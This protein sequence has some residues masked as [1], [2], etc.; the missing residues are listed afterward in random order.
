MSREFKQER[1]II[2]KDEFEG[3]VKKYE[4]C[5]FCDKATKIAEIL[6]RSPSSISREVKR[7]FSKKKNVDFYLFFG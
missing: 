7:N 2:D 1:Y 5:E 4:A 3:L 6:G